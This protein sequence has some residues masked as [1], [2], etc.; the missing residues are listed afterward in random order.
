L[1]VFPHGQ[2]LEENLIS[3]APPSGAEFLISLSYI[4]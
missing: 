1:Y 3:S 2:K 4:F